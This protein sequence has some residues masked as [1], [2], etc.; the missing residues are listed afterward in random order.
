MSTSVQFLLASRINEHLDQFEVSKYIVPQVLQN[1]PNKFECHENYFLISLDLLLITQLDKAVT[2]LHIYVG[3]EKLIFIASSADA[4][5]HLEGMFTNI[6]LT[7]TSFANI[8]YFLFDYIT[9]NDLPFLDDFEQKITDIEDDLLV[10]EP[11]SAISDIITLRKNLLTLKRYYEQFDIVFDNLL[12]NEIGLFTD[13][14]LLRLKILHNKMDRLL[15]N[16]VNLRE[17]ITQVREAYQAQVDI[18]MNRLMK[19]FTL[20]SL[21]FSPL[22][23]IVGWYGM[24]LKMPEFSWS[25]GYP[26]VILLSILVTVLS[27]LLFKKNKWL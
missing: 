9:K 7:H 1:K 15:Y 11:K 2:P 13:K 20:I 5:N 24:N 23:L 17:Y 12:E 27:I 8:L 4:L 18:S 6:D 25:F 21:I 26:I 10:T 16:V 19:I 14:E 3:R 22:T